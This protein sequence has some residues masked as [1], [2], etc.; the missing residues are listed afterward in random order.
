[1]RFAM[2]QGR[3]HLWFVRGRR[4]VDDPADASVH[5]HPDHV[6]FLAVCDPES[7]LDRYADLGC[8]PPCPRDAAGVLGVR[9]AE[10]A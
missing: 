8:R 10:S 9:F 4:G 1:M 3:G 2:Y 5:G 7:E 6:C